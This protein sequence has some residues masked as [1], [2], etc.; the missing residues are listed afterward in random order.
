MNI[1]KDLLYGKTHEWLKKNNDGTAT[2]GISDFAQH[3]MGDIVFAECKAVNT[4]IKKGDAFCELE[5]VK[6]AESAYMPVS[7]TIV[8]IN[9]TIVDNYEIINKSPY[10]DGWL[11]K[12][13]I[14]NEAELKELL[15]PVQYEK[16]VAEEEAKH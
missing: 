6:A 5:S 8:A 7:G 2:I 1:P 4:S 10:T 3:A 14:S 11:V 12:I 15:N 16:L 9:E 13:K